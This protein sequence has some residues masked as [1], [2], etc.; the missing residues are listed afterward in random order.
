MLNDWIEIVALLLAALGS[1]G[2]GQFLAKWVPVWISQSKIAAEGRLIDQEIRDK[3][4]QGR[5]SDLNQNKD[6]WDYIYKL[7][8]QQ[9]ALRTEMVEN[10]IACEDRIAGILAEHRQVLAMKDQ[11]FNVLDAEVKSLREL[12]TRVGKVLKGEEE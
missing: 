5:L 3:E 4:R 1:G 8:D 10:E 12:T 6:L 11:Q 7:Q 2:L 9:L